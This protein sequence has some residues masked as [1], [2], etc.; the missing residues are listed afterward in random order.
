MGKRDPQTGKRVLSFMA[1]GAL[2]VAPVAFAACGGAKTPEAGNLD[3]VEETSNVA[4][5]EPE[6]EATNVDHTADEHTNVGQEP[7]EPGG[8]DEA[9]PE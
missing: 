8:D 7:D 1:T 3:H 4:H 5:E 2:V 6:A 9:A